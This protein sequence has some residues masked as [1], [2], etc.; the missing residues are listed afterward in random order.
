MEKIKKIEKSLTSLIKKKKTQINKSRNEKVNV[1]TD[2]TEIQMSIR[3]YYE[4]LYGNKMDNWEEMDK[5]LES[6]FI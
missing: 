1:T 5:F 3:D 6:E 2:N 4:Q